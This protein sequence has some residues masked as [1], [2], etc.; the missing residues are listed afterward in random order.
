MDQTQQSGEA[1]PVAFH[2]Y[3]TGP[4]GELLGVYRLLPEYCTLCPPKVGE[5]GK[6]VRAQLGV[7]H[8]TK[9][10]RAETVQCLACDYSLTRPRRDPPGRR[11]N[12]G[13]SE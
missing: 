6:L 11:M 2:A 1:K 3:L 9:D 10:G 5:N 7:I 13:L 12:G 8:E 4:S